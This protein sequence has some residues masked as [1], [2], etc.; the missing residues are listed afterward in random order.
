MAD[1]ELE[2]IVEITTILYLAKLLY[3]IKRFNLVTENFYDVIVTD[4]NGMYDAYMESMSSLIQNVYE[5][6]DTAYSDKHG[7]SVEIFSSAEFEEFCVLAG[8][9]GEQNN[10]GEDDNPYMKNANEEMGEYFN[11][12]YSL[13]WK[14]YPHTNPKRKFHSRFALFTSECEWVDLGL[15]ALG[16]IK[17]NEWFYEQVVKLRALLNQEVAA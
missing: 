16:L 9:F 15:V 10:L 6:Y 1:V 3:D 14:L 2:G 11:F 4:E 8:K 13:D 7:T 5:Y 17:M 12:S